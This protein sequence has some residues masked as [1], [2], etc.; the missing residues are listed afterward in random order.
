MPISEEDKLRNL[1]RSREIIIRDLGILK[2]IE[3]NISIESIESTFGVSRG[4]INKLIK[5]TNIGSQ[6][7]KLKDFDEQFPQVLESLKEE[8]VLELVIEDHN[9]IENTES[10]Q[11]TEK[12]E[13]TLEIRNENSGEIEI[14]DE[15]GDEDRDEDV[16]EVTEKDVEERIPRAGKKR[17]ST[18]K[19]SGL[20]LRPLARTRTQR[21]EDGI[22]KPNLRE[23][24][25]AKD[26]LAQY[27]K[28]RRSAKTKSVINRN[29]ENGTENSGDDL[30]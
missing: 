7:E 22:W 24:M 12:L 16:V 27:D 14:G 29:Y 21:D 18:G 13:E 9:F 8:T 28:Y 1:Q 30:K 25:S 6:E 20:T 17:F 23:G 10:V 5:H 2:S 3:N 11:E 15:D 4:V 26:I 19:I